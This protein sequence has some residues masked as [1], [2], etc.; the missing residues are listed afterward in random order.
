MNIVLATTSKFKS[1]ILT[2]VGIKHTLMESNFDESLIN[3]DDVYK[4]T[5]LKSL[6]KAKSIIDKIDN[7]III[8]LDT[9]VYVNNKILEK[10]KD[11]LEAKEYINMCRNNKTEVIT[12]ISIINKELN[13]IITTHCITNVYMRDIDECDIEYYLQNEKNVLYASGFVIETIMSNFIDKIEGSYYNILGVP[14]DLIYK[15][16]NN[17]GYNLKDFT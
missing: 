3:I 14:V 6:G 13:T 7:G 16:L 1:N 10:P 17:Q 2:T 4:N 12:G 15:I 8:G 9:I 5:E 11:L